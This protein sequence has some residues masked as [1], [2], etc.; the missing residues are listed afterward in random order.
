M[1]S[2]SSNQEITDTKTTFVFSNNVTI[3][4]ADLAAS[5]AACGRQ[6]VSFLWDD[7]HKNCRNGSYYNTPLSTF[8]PCFKLKKG[9]VLEDPVFEGGEEVLGRDIN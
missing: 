8:G 6:W 7:V 2:T 9:P 4:S 3:K 1:Q 5:S